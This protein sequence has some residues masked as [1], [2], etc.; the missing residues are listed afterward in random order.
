MDIDF[1]GTVQTV[2]T[3][4]DGDFFAFRNHERMILGLRTTYGGDASAVLLNMA[5][6]PDEPFPSIATAQFFG[7]A[8]VIHLAKAILLPDLSEVGLDSRSDVADGPGTLFISPTGISMRVARRRE[9]YFYADVSTGSVTHSR[10]GG[11]EVPRWSVRLK[12]KAGADQTIINF[13]GPKPV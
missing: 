10:P 7:G 5:I 2:D 11:I 13:T 8:P 1:D 4:T 3:L 12:S 9:G 6:K